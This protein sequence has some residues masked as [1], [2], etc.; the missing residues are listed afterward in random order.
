MSTAR[1]KTRR[2]K[3]AASKR[4]PVV[5]RRKKTKKKK[6]YK[7]LATRRLGRARKLTDKLIDEAIELIL[8][9]LPV[10]RVCDYLSISSACYYE[11]KDKGERYLNQLHEARG[12]EFKEDEDCAVFVQA[13]VR[14]KAEW[15]LGI[16]RRSFQDKNK[17]TWIRDMTMM[18]RRD[19]VHWGR[20]ES[21]AN[22]TAA[23]LPDDSYL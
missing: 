11:W 8:E 1:K 19:R 18:E 3:T 21:F 6:Q 14:A 16:L 9:G 22:V 7:V 15:Q 4:R 12:P 5:Q 17:A 10:E 23:P 2:K 13:V 20:S